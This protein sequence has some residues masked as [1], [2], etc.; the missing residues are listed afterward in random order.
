M[1]NCLRISAFLLLFATALSCSQPSSV[2]PATPEETPLPSDP[3]QDVRS[4]D[5]ERVI[6]RRQEDNTVLIPPSEQRVPEPQARSG[7]P[8][9][10]A[11]RPAS[12]EPAARATAVAMH[13]V[14]A[15]T[16]LT[17]VMS[18]E[19]STGSSR[20]GDRFEATLSEPWTVGGKVVAERGATVIGRVAEVI[21][22]GRVKGKAQLKLVLAEIFPG[23]RSYR[24]NTE[25]FVAIAIDNKERDAAIIAGGAGVGAAIGAITG[26]K[27]GA[28]I[29]A[30]IGGGGGTAT[31]LATRGQE[32]K[33]EPET[34][35]NFVLDD[36][37]RLP[38]IRELSES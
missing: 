14:P 2:D 1:K 22:P 18:S 20:E 11:S 21:E 29:G 17:V 28:A 3:G 15:G 23:N 13:T 8:S 12:D 7:R 24:I 4:G 6:P 36:S 16:P 32:M 27:R 5:S 34:K 26:G 37:V 38:V 30:I 35:V 31:V 33:I 25:P 10:E 9:P 19:V